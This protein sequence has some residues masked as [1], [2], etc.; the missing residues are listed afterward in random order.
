MIRMKLPGV[1]H[2]IEKEMKVQDAIQYCKNWISHRQW[3][4]SNK[5][6][7]ENF[8]EEIEFQ[9]LCE[10]FKF[11]EKAD[12]VLITQ[13]I[14]KVAKKLAAKQIEK[15]RLKNAMIRDR[16]NFL[17]KKVNL[18]DQTKRLGKL[19]KSFARKKAMVV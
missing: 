5:I 9:Q 1:F 8:Q 15:I 13:S 7:F 11:H 12:R 19:R 3:L 10:Q 6:N 2:Q 4:K 18:N 17:D 16:K 14:Q